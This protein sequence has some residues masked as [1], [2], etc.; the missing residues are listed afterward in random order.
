LKHTWFYRLLLSYVPVIFVIGLSLLLMTY[1]TINEMSKK[2]VLKANQALTHN[3]MNLIDKTLSGLD[4]I[5]LYEILGNEEIKGFF[6]DYRNSDRDIRDIAAINA[7]NELMVNNPLIDSVYLYRTPDRTVLTPSTLTKLERFS[8]KIFVGN[9]VNSKKS[10]IWI[11]R[12]IGSKMLEKGDNGQN[13]VSLAKYARLADFSIMVINVRIDDIMQ[14]VRGITDTN[15]MFVDLANSDGQIFASTDEQ[16][17][18]GSL[19]RPGGKVLSEAYSPMTDWTIRTGNKSSHISDVVSSL[20][21]LWM[22]LGCV[23]VIAGILWIVLISRRNYK[24]IQLLMNRI[25][26]ARPAKRTDKVDEFK[27][28]ETAIGELVDETSQL[29]EQSKE[30]IAYRKRQLFMNLLEGESNSKNTKWMSELTDE[31]T[32]AMV[33]VAEI[34]KYDIFMQKYSNGN[35]QYLLKSVVS[36]VVQEMAEDMPFMIWAEWVDPNRLAILA[37]LRNSEKGEQD[38]VHFNEA[39]RAWVAGNLS[40]TLTIGVSRQIDEVKRVSESYQSALNA[41]NYKSSLGMDRIIT[42]EHIESGPRSEL[43]VKLEYMKELSQYYRAGNND[44]EER[45]KALFESLRETVYSRNDLNVFMK[46][47]ISHL[48]QE[49]EELPDELR[50][51]WNDGLEQEL[52]AILAQRETLEEMYRDFKRVLSDAYERMTR[53]RESKSNHQLVKDVKQFIDEHYRNPDL[54]LTYLSEEFGLNANYLSRLFRETFGV[55][56]IEHVTAVRIEAAK[57]LLVETEFT[58]Q[59]VGQ[60]VGYEQPLTFIRVFGKATGYTPGQYRKTKRA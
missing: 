2:S 54:S 39:L 26:D 50:S 21:Y 24:P 10:F 11:P 49:I 60:A 43:F 48:K 57:K 13:V 52:L 55:K 45:F 20:F 17:V 32:G 42:H 16:R 59:E 6:S 28:I 34:D 15:A 46:M 44:W 19:V 51:I 5:M 3:V 29:Q 56:F 25:A 9:S 37:L 8:D 38:F 47:L 1:L 53:I 36:S 40:F 23:I 18:D 35:D 14:I 41:L 31:V 33:A 7:L 58:I 12:S 22:I 30:N 4:S 27:F